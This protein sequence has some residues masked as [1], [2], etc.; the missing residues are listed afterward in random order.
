VGEVL[1]QATVVAAVSDEDPKNAQCNFDAYMLTG[2][3][4]AAAY[5]W[6]LLSCGSSSSED[7]KNAQY[8]FDAYM[9]TGAACS[10]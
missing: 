3:A 9:L 10:S 4:A 6:G 7:P 2:A 5:M 1:R 8:N